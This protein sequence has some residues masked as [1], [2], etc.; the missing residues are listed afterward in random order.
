MEVVRQR[1]IIFVIIFICMWPLSND[2]NLVSKIANGDDRAFTTLYEKCRPEFYGFF[3]GSCTSE[4]FANRSMSR[5]KDGG[6]YLDDLYQTSCMKLYNMIIGGRMFVNGNKI[7][8]VGRDGSV[9]PMTASLKTFL[10]SIGKLTLKEFER[11]EKRYVGFDTIER[12]LHNDP[13]YECSD[14]LYNQS[15]SASS[16]GVEASV[17]LSINPFADDEKKDALVR[18]IVN[19]MESPCKEI[20]TFTYFR[21]DGKKMKGDDIA[22]QMGYSSADVV[23][24]QRTRCKKKFQQ[25]FEAELAKLQ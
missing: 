10:T 17:E 23:K 12:T 7:Y 13:D 5:F 19:N 16:L 24:N 22:K 8:V 6:Y 21:E 4:V 1:M 11:G 25:K 15:I 9:N 3:N 14:E 20:F 18:S 2:S